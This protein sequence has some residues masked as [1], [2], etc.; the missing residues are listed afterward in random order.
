MSPGAVPGAARDQMGERLAR[1]FADRLPGSAPVVTGIRRLSAG[2]SRQNWAFDLTYRSGR[3]V[4]T[5]SLIL[6]RDPKGGLVETDRQTEFAVLSCLEATK[7]PAPVA[8]WIDV[9][10]TWFGSPSLIMR[11]EPGDCDY[12]ILNGDRPLPERVALARAFCDLVGDV[13]RVDVESCG[14]VDVLAVPVDPARDQLDYWESVLREDQLE[15]YPEID[16]ALAWL[17]DSLPPPA[18]PVLVH[19]DFKPGNIL[20]EGPDVSALLDWELAHLGDPAEDLGWVTQP[21]RTREHLIDGH[22]SQ[23]D[24]LEH[25]ERHTGT[26]VAPD[27]LR[28]WN[29]FAALRTAVMQVSGLRSYLEGRSSEPYRPTSSV[30]GTLLEGAWQLEGGTG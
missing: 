29:V 24:L 28:W 18:A 4:V 7:V 30:L 10:G 15:A 3:E 9:D 23:S 17:R 11:R 14:L 16:L 5:E 1:F 6:R 25:Y 8:R 20:V 12:Y 19:G 2:R 21:L 22:W 26:S 27:S 13:H